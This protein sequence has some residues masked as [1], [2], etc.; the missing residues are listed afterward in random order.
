MN[1]LI[2][3]GTGLVGRALCQQWLADGHR[4]TVLS[5]QPG[6]VPQ[7]CGKTVSGVSSLRGIPRDAEFQA[8]IN[9]AGEPIADRRWSPRRKQALRDSRIALTAELV[10]YLQHCKQRP[11]TLISASAVGYYGD[12]GDH[13]LDE[14]AD[15]VNDFAHQ[16]CRDW[17]REAFVAES[18]GVRV[19]VLRI[20]LVVAADGGFLS[21]MAWPFRL[22]LG[23]P[24]GTGEQWMS[25]IH[26]QDLV[27]I[28]EFL[29]QHEVLTGVFNAT[30]PHPVSNLEFT[31]TLGK[32]LGKPT[33]FRVPATMLKMGLGEMSSLLLGGQ[34]VL[35]KR[36]QLSGYNFCYPRLRDALEQACKP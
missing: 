14:D 17:E 10:Q 6:R 11:A 28:L 24:L 30:A 23:G 25:W 18:L 20:G 21:R 1:I 7:L 3:G 15:A 34:R 22:G 29:L 9:L 36:L 33:P 13:P 8:V 35:P 4:L 16:L 32:V 31:Q 12:Q 26:R 5:R 27:K 2:T 19:C